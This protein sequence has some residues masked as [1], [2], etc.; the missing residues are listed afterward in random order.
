M[1]R[2]ALLLRGINV[3]RAHR[4]GMADLRE[5]LAAEGH[6]EV[7]TLL[8]SGNVVLDSES[9]SEELARSVERALERRFGFPVPTLLR[10][11][12]E[13]LG[14]VARDPLG[15]VA[16][17]PTRY[18]VTFFAAE[19]PA[20]LSERLQATDPGDDA[21]AVEGREVYVWCPHGQLDSPLVTAVGTHRG[22]PAGTARNW[23]T[24]LKLADLLQR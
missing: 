22:G 23:A 6:T 7:R 1:T 21:F 10:S 15:A 24:V 12:D 17:D 20:E 5:L 19:V 11:R 8:Q 13:L 18:V 16:T 14:V 9:P 4:I 3:G 2:Y